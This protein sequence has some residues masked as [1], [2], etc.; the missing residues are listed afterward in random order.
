MAMLFFAFLNTP[1]NP[2]QFSINHFKIVFVNILLPVACFFIIHPFDQHL[3]I[4][5]FVITAIPTAAAAPVIAEIMKIRVGILT[6]AVLLGTPLMALV[7][8]FMLAFFMDVSEDIPTAD[9]VLPIIIL[10]FTPLMISQ[11]IR[12]F[13]PRLTQKLLKFSF[14]SFPLFLVNVFIA[15]GNASFFIQSNPNL[16]PS[17]I[18][19]IFLL[20]CLIGTLQFQIGRLIGKGDEPLAY[21]LAM[22]RKNTMIGLWLG[23][24]YFSPI[25]ALG[26]IG[27][28][29]FHN[30]YNSF[31]IW[32]REKNAL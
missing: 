24:T 4:V 2:R 6:I 8:P 14:I 9:L 1:V 32:Q 25:V 17:M 16:D 31:Q 13:S 7:L 18:L 22:G 21:S 12:Q 28:I 30:I 5:A 20:V 26:P 3:A 11:L 23:I 29:I 19:K 15:C 27:Y 10:V